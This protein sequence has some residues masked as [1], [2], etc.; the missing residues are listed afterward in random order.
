[1]NSLKEE[2]ETVV[3]PQALAAVLRPIETA[4]GMP[5]VSYTDPG[6]FGF[7][8]DH[9]LSRN[10][11]AIAFEAKL[12]NAMIHPLDFMGIPVLLTR[13]KD[14]V[15]RVFH[16]VC[17]HRGFKLVD[18]ER[19]TGGR[20]VCPYHSWTY[21]LQGDLV[22]TPHIGGVG[23]HEVEGFN[24]AH[25]GLKE[26]RSHVWMGIVFINLDGHAPDFEQDMEAVIGRTQSLMGTAGEDEM[27]Y[28]RDFGA[29]E[30]TVR[31]NWK[32]VIEN[33]LEAYHLPFIHPKL[34]A[35]S[36]LADHHCG[37]HGEKYSGQYTTTFD[38]G[39]DSENPLP[40]FSGWSPDRLS[41]GDYPA[42]YPNLL[43]GLQANHVFAMIVHPL[44]ADSC[45]EEVALFYCG[46][47]ACGDVFRDIR[48]INLETWT[49]VFN[50][51][52]G[53]CERMQAGRRSPGYHGGGFSPVL[54][55]CSH[56]FHQWVARQYRQAC[57]QDGRH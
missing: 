1:M 57:D 51:D 30:M 20:I 41:I 40:M 37:I 22:A 43:L 53:P 50:E 29:L 45:F 28:A 54:D 4:T 14:G 21:S 26:I 19:R 10:W 36:P 16:N 2:G 35:Y 9:V 18:K 6:L 23:V 56:H 46:E 31:C 17:S 24:C 7:E 32:L 49:S 15:T 52:V 25:K 33:F 27:I 3:S 47:G 11:V 5:N 38:P 39:I 48:R 13:S 8:R 12:G 42:V 44:S 55:R 34:N